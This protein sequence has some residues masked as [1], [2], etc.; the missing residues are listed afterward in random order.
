MLLG[1]ELRAAIKEAY[2][3]SRA[4]QAAEDPPGIIP[5]WDALQLAMRIA[6]LDVYAAGR[7]LGAQEERECR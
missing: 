3:Q 6:F 4:Q 5:A 7:A 2:E 1:D